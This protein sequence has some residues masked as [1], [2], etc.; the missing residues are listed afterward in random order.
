M[1]THKRAD[2]TIHKIGHLLIVAGP[3]AAGKST[4]L[5]NLSSADPLV[6]REHLGAEDLRSWSRIGATRLGTTKQVQESGVTLY[7]AFLGAP[8]SSRATGPLG[9]RLP[10]LTR[11]AREISL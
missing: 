8:E 5:D 7:Y 2:A 3:T 9:N 1:S 6:L 11:G 10:A 4:V